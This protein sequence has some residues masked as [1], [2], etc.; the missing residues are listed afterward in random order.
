MAL[1]LEGRFTGKA[2]RGDVG[3]RGPNSKVTVNIDCQITEG[4]HKGKTFQYVGKCDP[5]NI[6]YTKS[7]AKAVGWKGKD[8]IQTL[9]RDIKAAGLTVDFDLQIARFEKDGELQE[10]TAVNRIHGIREAIPVVGDE[11]GKVNSWFEEDAPAGGGYSSAP[12]NDYSS[13]DSYSSHPNAPGADSDV[14]F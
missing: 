6:K 14:P 5:D 12:R 7:A 3:R 10:W 9:D 2:V 11:A 4:E 1:L 8:I 13:Q